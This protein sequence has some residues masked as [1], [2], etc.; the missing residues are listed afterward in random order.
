MCGLMKDDAFAWLFGSYQLVPMAFPHGVNARYGARKF[1]K[2]HN[3]SIQSCVRI[4]W[5]TDKRRMVQMH[6]VPRPWLQTEVAWANLVV[7]LSGERASIELPACHLLCT[8]SPSPTQPRS[9]DAHTKRRVATRKQSFSNFRECNRT[10][11]FHLK[12]YNY[13]QW[14]FLTK[15]RKT[16]NTPSISI[17]QMAKRTIFNASH[18][19]IN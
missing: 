6:C 13:T 5:E 15:K 19:E 9:S 11:L 18:R 10:R 8:S 14:I 16:Q 12:T 7:E 1:N 2:I 17:T 4:T 3:E